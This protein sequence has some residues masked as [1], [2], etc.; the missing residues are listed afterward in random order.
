MHPVFRR[1]LDSHDD[2]ELHNGAHVSL[3]V[4]LGGVLKENKRGSKFRNL[5]DHR[6]LRSLAALSR[7]RTHAPVVVP[8]TL[9]RAWT[10]GFYVLLYVKVHVRSIQERSRETPRQQHRLVRHAAFPAECGP[11]GGFPTA[12]TLAVRMC[13]IYRRTCCIWTASIRVSV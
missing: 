10:A 1:M 8:R 5:A 4:R 13:I 7:V 11:R 9:R 6:L 12:P 3:Q 2:K